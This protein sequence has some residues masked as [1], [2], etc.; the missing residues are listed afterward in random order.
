MGK[1]KEEEE[2]KREIEKE[3]IEVE[4]PEGKRGRLT[5]H[6]FE[7][8]RRI[9][10]KDW[11]YSIIDRSPIGTGGGGVVFKAEPREEGEVVIGGKKE[12]YAVKILRK[13]RDIIEKTLAEDQRQ[14][15][16][17]EKE[18]RF[19]K[20]GELMNLTDIVVRI[21]DYGTLTNLPKEI[22]IQLYKDPFGW[23][24]A[25]LWD[26]DDEFY[27]IVME[28]MHGDM[29]Q[30]IRNI[31]LTEKFT[32]YDALRKQMF[33][34]FKSL[35]FA[36]YRL[37]KIGIMLNDI[38]PGNILYM[39]DRDIEPPALILKFADYGLSCF[40]EKIP[41]EVT[42]ATTEE[43]ITI[44]EEL[45]PEAD[46]RRNNCTEDTFGLTEAYADPQYSK[47]SIDD[48]ETIAARNIWAL[49]QTMLK[50][51]TL[52]MKIIY[53]ARRFGTK[54]YRMLA[55]RFMNNLG[56]TPVYYLDLLI[57]PYFKPKLFPVVEELEVAL[58]SLSILLQLGP[59]KRLKGF[60]DLY[61]GYKYPPTIEEVKTLEFYR[62]KS[63][64]ALNI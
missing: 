58:K 54:E 15:S 59:E 61:K 48:F 31:N 18:V 17:F 29:V 6:K 52:D 62:L 55:H 43:E 56:F 46:V 7:Y 16:V 35:V 63:R 2:M 50:I 8:K 11:K 9:P 49:G 47:D 30:W 3:E 20:F 34:I 26:P 1:K 42:K 64:S 21:F 60:I 10:Y 23:D 38:K 12:R 57:Q 28:K 32:A 45:P 22:G 5:K 27:F 44:W 39:V 19:A 36:L 14:K 13:M 37:I 4:V 41:E 51:L 25:A 24:P 33:E 40:Y 53:I